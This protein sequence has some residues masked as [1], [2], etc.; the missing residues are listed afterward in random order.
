MSIRR[1]IRSSRCS[2]AA[3]PAEAAGSSIRAQSNSSTSLGEVVPRMSTRPVC[4]TSA[5]RVNVAMPSR[6]ACPTMDVS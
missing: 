6:S 2:N 3:S 1:S 4:I 5:S